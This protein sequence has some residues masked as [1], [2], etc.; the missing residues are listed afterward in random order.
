MNLEI[1]AKFR[2]E[3]HEPVRQSLRDRGAT[4]RGRVR[5]TNTIFDTNDRTLL[6][7]DKG[8]RVR[9]TRLDDGSEGQATLTYKGPRRITKVKTREEIE[10]VVED[11]RKARTLLARLGFVEA[12][13]FE[14]LRET[15]AL[16]DCTVELDEV[17]ELGTFVEI[18]GPDEATV[19]RAQA[20]IG[21]P[22][23]ALVRE[24]Y[25]SMVSRIR[26]SQSS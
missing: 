25:V 19:A 8:L 13:T 7:A 12:I 1:E 18:E 15:W 10:I 4:C 6:S 20:S 2:V 16:E 14:K 22:E 21:L 11:A 17:P 24:S 26:G 23:T 9:S 5:E 3:D